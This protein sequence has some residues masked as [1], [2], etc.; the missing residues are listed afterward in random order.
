MHGNGVQPVL[1]AVLMATVPLWLAAALVLASVVPAFAGLEICNRMHRPA[2]VAIGYKSGGDWVSEGWWNINPRDCKTVVTGDLE[3]RYYYYHDADSG[4]VGE[5]YH[6]C[7]EDGVFTIWGGENCAERGYDRLNFR[8][9]DT[10]ATATAFTFTLWD[11]IDE[12]TPIGKINQTTTSSSGV[13]IDFGEVN[14]S[15]RGWWNGLDEPDTQIGFVSENTLRFTQDGETVSDFSYY[16]ASA[17]PIAA[18]AEDIYLV[19][20][21]R[22]TGEQFCYGVL[23]YGGDDLEIR[24]LPDGMVLRYTRS[25]R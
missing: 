24:Y 6:F 12:N 13:E 10:G 15:V 20:F 23:E 8:L 7:T 25:A 2:S 5:G 19:M 9:I 11:E 18:P 4:F 14:E 16:F 21:D 3:Q 22:D 1:R 17:C